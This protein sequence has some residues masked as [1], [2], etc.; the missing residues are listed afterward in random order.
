[1]R[2]EKDSGGNGTEWGPDVS[3]SKCFIY[4]NKK[5]LYHNLLETAKD[6]NKTQPDPCM[7]ELNIENGVCKDLGRLGRG[8][9]GG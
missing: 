5:E 6:E 9:L 8:S 1:M 4:G 3:G 2:F 7:D